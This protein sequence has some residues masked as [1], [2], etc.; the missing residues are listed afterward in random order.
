MAKG[1]VM[2]RQLSRPA[3]TIVVGAGI[4]LFALEV[5]ISSQTAFVAR[6]P[7]VRGGAAGAGA[8]LPGLTPQELDYFNAGKKEF[9]E[10][11]ELDEG[12]GPTMNLD[13]CGGCHLQP[14][15][16]GSS[17]AVNPQ[18]AFANKDGGTDTLPPNFSEQAG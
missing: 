3:S 12:I 14:A 15:L 1:A 8:P 13:S 5:K 18:F 11:E 17:P 7:G 6:D 10:A 4:A 2:T 9:E 16:G